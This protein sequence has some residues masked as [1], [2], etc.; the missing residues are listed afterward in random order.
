MS[1][2]DLGGKTSIVTGSVPKG[3]WE[4]DST[5]RGDLETVPIIGE[6]LSVRMK[7]RTQGRT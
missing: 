4:R 7:L 1:F 2:V 3:G 6:T 5:G